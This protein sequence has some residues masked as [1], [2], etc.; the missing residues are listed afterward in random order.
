MRK[1]IIIIL[2]IVAA[3]TALTAQVTNYALRLDAGGSV[4]CGEVPE[5]S[6]A[7]SYTLQ[8]WLNADQWTPNATV[9]AV[10]DGFGI[11]LGASGTINV[12]V[13][14][15]TLPVGST[16][17]VAGR[18][19]QI[20]LVC[21]EGEASVL[22]DGKQCASATL[23]QFPVAGELVMGGDTFAGRIDDVRLWS[24]ALL[25]DFDYFINNTLNKWCPQYDSLVAYY[26]FDYDLCDNVVDMKT[27]A[28]SDYNH[29][30]IFSASG[31]RR[32][33]VT[34]NAGLR[35]LVNGAY[36]NNSRFYDRGIPRDQYLL[37]ND[38]IILGINSY[39]DGHLRYSTPC[40]HGTITGGSYLAEFE[41]RGGVLQLDGTG[42]MA[43][44]NECLI[45]TVNNAGVTALGYTFESWIYL[46]EWTEGAYIFRKESADGK[47]GFSIS[48]GSEDTKQIVVRC[49]GNRYVNQN[50]MKVGEWVHLG[51]TTNQGTTTRL[52]YMFCFNGTGKFAT[53]SVSDGSMDYTPVGMADCVAY[54]G[55]GLKAK[56]DETVVWNR[57]FSESDIA[58]HSRK[59]PM[60]S[61]GGIQTAD[62][63]NNA[64]A[65]FTYDDA[66]NPGYDS[67]SQ[68]EWLRIMKSAYEGYRGY[69]VRI[70]VASH[71][72]WLSTIADASK[73]KIFAADLARLSAPYDGVELDLEWAD[74]VSD[75]ANYGLLADEIRAVLP[76]DKTFAVSCHAYGAYRYPVAKMDNVDAF[77]FQQYGPQNTFFSWGNFTSSCKNFINYGFP[78]NKIMLSYST[79]TSGP[80]N[81][82][83]TKA[84][85]AVIGVRNG[86]LDGDDY[87]PQDD[88]ERGY[89]N[90]YYY[91]FTGPKQTYRR[92]KYCVDNDLQGI[93]Y[94]DMGNDVPV[95]HKYNLAKY[96][97]YALN[98]NVDSIVT[99]VTVKHSSAVEPVRA[100]RSS[101][102]LKCYPN[103][104][105]DLLY[106][107]CDG[108]IGDIE[109]YSTDGGAC[110]L[111]KQVELSGAVLSV[112]HLAPGMYVLRATCGDGI[113]RQTKFFKR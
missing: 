67:H 62:I 19:A 107:Q 56:L 59:V 7:R 20:T 71:T 9:L 43:C 46:D 101:E 1:L 74:A 69:K 103:P 44:T 41:G 65:Y 108:N 81:E 98:A 23:P 26:K 88:M 33:V 39:S 104:T 55:E 45:P 93:F 18:W 36:T 14:D 25:P 2:T 105:A 53:A 99:K 42:G 109:I 77:T 68:D 89:Y 113:V 24:D 29:H 50:C 17:L 12:G 92:A 102:R 21:D 64:C 75:W 6:A 13:G 66:S 85:S 16:S 8:L 106:V 15:L 100:E 97:G 54:I 95:T 48:L 63:L 10:G 90:Y 37:A 87:E 35:Y 78:K 57:K 38:L 96:C 91:Y 3:T 83:G 47:Q 31:A 34:D 32:E 82:S 70:S 40:C 28:S 51:I 80:Y 30:G 49:N 73:R 5:M 79:T 27:L 84:G 111:S 112:S 11:T 52:T 58:A 110:L 72:G 86:L 4:A 94:W 61:I 60:P 76:A 22:V